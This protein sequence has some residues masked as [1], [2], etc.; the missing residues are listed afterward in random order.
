MKT[1]KKTRGVTLAGGK[2]G[3][4]RFLESYA[5][6]GVLIRA[7]EEAGITRTTIRDW[8]KKDPDFAEKFAAAKEE[9]TERLL[10][11]ARRRAEEGTTKPVF[12]QGVECG[13]IRE[14]SDTLLIFLLKGLM[15]ETFRERF[16]A[17]LSGHDGGPLRIV[18][19][20]IIE[21]TTLEHSPIE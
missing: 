13:Q 3:K 2:A 18:E 14:Y 7:A 9:A 20:V 21:P 15:P 11:E 12:Y 19:E 6:R 10:A 4:A 1:S 17:R 8:L 5:R 16:D